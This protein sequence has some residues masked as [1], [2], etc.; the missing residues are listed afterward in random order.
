M[1]NLANKE[2]STTKGGEGK[3]KSRNLF[4]YYIKLIYNNNSE[5]SNNVGGGNNIHQGG[6]LEQ[7]CLG[8]VER[9]NIINYYKE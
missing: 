5:T 6:S 1:T 3:K 9:T 4:E 8:G 7:R 2:G